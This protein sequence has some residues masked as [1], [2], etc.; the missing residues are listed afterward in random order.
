M[1]R[2]N[3]RHIE[4]AI[5]AAQ[6]FITLTSQNDIDGQRLIYKKAGKSCIGELCFPSLDFI[7]SMFIMGGINEGQ[8]EITEK[9]IPC[10]ANVW[11]PCYGSEQAGN[12]AY[13]ASNLYKSKNCRLLLRWTN[14]I[15]KWMNW[16]IPNFLIAS[17][18]D[19]SPPLPAKASFSCPALRVSRGRRVIPTYFLPLFKFLQRYMIPLHCF[20]RQSLKV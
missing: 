7:A 11:T 15:I 5:T 13:K 12:W 4:K 8:K 17:C 9:P 16:W 2:A 10:P 19:P 18:N 3:N 20:D 14:K 6:K 1:W